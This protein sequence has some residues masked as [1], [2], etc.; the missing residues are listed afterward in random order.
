MVIYGLAVSFSGFELPLALLAQSP[1]GSTSASSP[2]SPAPVTVSLW[3]EALHCWW[4]KL[5]FSLAPKTD[6]TPKEKHGPKN[7]LLQVRPFGNFPSC[8]WIF[9]VPG[10]N[11]AMF[12]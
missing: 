4:F 12:M 6:L 5:F 9:A 10:Y 3:H 2:A 7:L 8:S 11:S 1:T